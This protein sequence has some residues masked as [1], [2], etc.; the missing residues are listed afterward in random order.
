[1]FSQVAVLIELILALKSS[2]VDRRAYQVMSRSS[3]TKSCIVDEL[4]LQLPCYPLYV[5][6]SQNN[7]N[8]D[9]FTFPAAV[10]VLEFCTH[11]HFNFSFTLLFRS[12]SQNNMNIVVLLFF[13][14]R[15]YFP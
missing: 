6:F 10:T 9:A 12:F 8:A 13:P 7:L 15:L 2:G 4:V 11:G 3:S 5:H 1:M 14:Q